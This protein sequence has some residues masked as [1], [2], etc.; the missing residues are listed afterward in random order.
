MGRGVLGLIAFIPFDSC[1]HFLFCPPLSL[2]YQGL[3]NSLGLNKQ[4]NITYKYET[5]NLTTFIDSK[6]V[7][8]IPH[9]DYLM[10]SFITTT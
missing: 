5:I 2:H 1:S 10:F 9:H 8:I 4:T 6:S 3:G 7:Y